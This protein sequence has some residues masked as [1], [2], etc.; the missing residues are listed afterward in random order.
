M[1]Q[2]N[3]VR[4]RSFLAGSFG[5]MLAAG[6]GTSGTSGSAGGSNGT[7]SFSYLLPDAFYAW[8]N[9]NKWYPALTKAANAKIDLIDGGPRDRYA[10]QVDLKLTSGGIQDAAIA[11]M[12]Q[13]FVYGPQ[14]AFVDLKPLIEQNAPHIK[15]YIADNPDYEGLISTPDG[16]IYGL[17]AEYPKICPV[18]FYR[19]DMF[20]KA[21]INTPPRTIAEFTDALRK[22]KAAYRGTKNYFPYLGRENLLNLGYAFKAQDGIENGKIHGIYESGGGLDIHSPGFRAMV[23]WYRTLYAE[24]LIDPEWVAG[25]ATEESWQ[26]KM[27]TGR[28]TVST[29][30]FTR[31]SWFMQNGGPKNDPKFAMAVLPAFQDTDGTQLKVP[32]AKRYNVDQYLVISAKSKKAADV[33]KFMDFTFSD[34]GQTLMHWGVEGTS[35]KVEGG[36][37]AYAVSFEREGNQPLGTPVWNFLQDRLTFPAPVDNATYYQWMD[38]LTKSFATEYFNNYLEVNPVLRYTPQQLEE[39]S[40]LDAAVSP[41]I[42]AEVVKFVTGKR[43]MAQWSTFLSEADKKGVTKITELDQAAYDAMGK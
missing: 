8:L 6:C 22:L 13:V 2:P 41:F 1:N 21:G 34:K 7:L 4:R 39:R 33:I 17:V 15:K 36:K 24:G 10:Q 40:A 23:E 26:T 38:K 5:L 18:T 19:A 3:L 35:Y 30:F 14:G 20:E 16:K 29:D 11:T 37:N 9:D 12:S 28:G 27:L 42:D 43:P 25:T 32:A 31:P